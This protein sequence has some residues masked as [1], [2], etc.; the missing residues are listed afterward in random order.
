M[1]FSPKEKES[2]R[3][4]PGAKKKGGKRE[5]KHVRSGGREEGKLY[6]KEEGERFFSDEKGR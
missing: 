5:K 3:P 6:V 1:I 4:F 2:R